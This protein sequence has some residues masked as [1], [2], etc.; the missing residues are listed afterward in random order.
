[1]P[2]RPSAARRRFHTARVI[3]KRITKRIKVARAIAHYELV[4]IVSGRLDDQQYYVG[5]RRPR[6]CA[7]SPHKNLPNADRPARRRGLAPARRAGVVSRRNLNHPQKGDKK[8]MAAGKCLRPS[9]PIAPCPRKKA[10]ISRAISDGETR[11]RTGDTTIFSRATF[12]SEFW[13]ICRGFLSV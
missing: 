8:E 13:P 9:A 3:A 10:L 7:C 11:T 4:E 6:C 1:M 12:R 5:C 2:S